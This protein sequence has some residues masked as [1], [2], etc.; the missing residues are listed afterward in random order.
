MS[1]SEEESVVSNEEVSNEDASEEEDIEEVVAKPVKAKRT[2]KT[3]KGK[4]KKDPNKPKRN[5]SAFFLF[6]TANRAKF[7]EENPELAFGDLVSQ[8]VTIV[9]SFSIH[10]DVCIVR[11][12]V[13]CLF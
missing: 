2:R 1:S 12:Y 4:K 3:K 5:M 8:F 6:S 13:C 9:F 10:L 11:L 7:K